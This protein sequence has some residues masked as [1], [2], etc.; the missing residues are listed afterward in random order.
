MSFHYHPGKANVVANAGSKL[1]MGGEARVEE[2]RKELVK[3]DK[4]L[5]H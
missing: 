3:D 1:S 5:S 2:R 4:T